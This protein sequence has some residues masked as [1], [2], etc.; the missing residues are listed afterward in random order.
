MRHFNVS[1]TVVSPDAGTM[2]SWLTLLLTLTVAMVMS[3]QVQ[4]PPRNRL[5]EKGLPS[6]LR[7]HLH[8]ATLLEEGLEEVV[9]IPRY[10]LKK[11]VNI[12]IMSLYP[13]CLIVMYL[14]GC[15]YTPVAVMN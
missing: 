14:S 1:P 10:V 2:A 6:C 7:A 11:I 5:Q 8:A 3:S 9:F 4:G 12:S 13:W 15:L